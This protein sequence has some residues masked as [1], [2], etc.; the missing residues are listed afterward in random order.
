MISATSLLALLLL[1]GGEAGADPV[2]SVGIPVPFFTIPGGQADAGIEAAGRSS[3][4]ES[5]TFTPLTSGSAAM[6]DGYTGF[7]PYFQVVQSSAS[8]QVTVNATASDLPTLRRSSSQGR[9]EAASNSVFVGTGES[10]LCWTFRDGGGWVC[11]LYHPGDDW[12]RGRRIDADGPD[13]W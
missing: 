4:T 1:D 2:I 10:Q 12:A 3:A 8:N 11:L 13:L 7:K 9:A 6:A 5:Y